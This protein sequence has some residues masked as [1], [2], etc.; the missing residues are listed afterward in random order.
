VATYDERFLA[1]VLAAR[2]TARLMAPCVLLAFVALGRRFARAA[3]LRR[4]ACRAAA[5]THA[6][7]LAAVAVVIVLEPPAAHRGGELLTEVGGGSAAAVIVAGWWLW[8]RP[9]YR[10]LTYWP[11][12]VLAFTYLFL[13]RLGDTAPRIAAAPAL[14]GPVMLLLLG[15]LAVRV[16]ADTSRSALSRRSRAVPAV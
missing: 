6:I 9:F 15:A 5:V 14:F 16:W 3:A 2:W 13:A 1:A 10:W 7:H 8:D 4:L 12:G 11:W